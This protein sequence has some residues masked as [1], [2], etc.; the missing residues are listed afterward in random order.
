MESEINPP[1]PQRLWEGK[2]VDIDDEAY[3]AWVANGCPTGPVE[4]ETNAD[5]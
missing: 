4:E 5:Y 2:L 3:E 1:R